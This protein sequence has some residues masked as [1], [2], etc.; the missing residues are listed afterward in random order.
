MTRKKEKLGC[1]TSIG[2]GE[3]VTIPLKGGSGGFPCQPRV[4]SPSP[5]VGGIQVSGPQKNTRLSIKLPGKGGIL[6]AQGKAPAI[7]VHQIGRGRQR[8]SFP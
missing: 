4:G 3:K 6:R 2:V 7:T 5:S 8:S 1:W